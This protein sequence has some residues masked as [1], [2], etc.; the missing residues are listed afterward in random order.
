MSILPPNHA[1]HRLQVPNPAN[2]LL[3]VFGPWGQTHLHGDLKG[4]PLAFH[5]EGGSARGAGGARPGT[6]GPARRKPL[7]PDSPRIS[8][9]WTHL[10]SLPVPGS[11][12]PEGCHAPLCTVSPAITSN[13]CPQ[14]SRTDLPG[15][16]KCCA[17]RQGVGP[18][19]TDSQTHEEERKLRQ[20]ADGPGVIFPETPRKI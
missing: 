5:S 8:Q 2:E 9:H 13:L 17:Q 20:S 14:R 1:P 3:D 11:V 10:S 19:R 12:H 6:L 18:R 4:R 7:R 15:T 16:Q